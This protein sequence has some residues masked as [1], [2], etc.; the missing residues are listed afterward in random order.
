MAISPDGKFIYIYGIIYSYQ[1][2]IISIDD[3]FSTR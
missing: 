3:M 2:M 1:L